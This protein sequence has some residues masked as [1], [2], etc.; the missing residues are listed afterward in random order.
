MEEPS[1]VPGR[2]VSAEIAPLYEQ[3]F[4]AIATRDRAWFER[5]FAEDLRVRNV[6]RAQERGKEAMIALE[7][8]IPPLAWRTLEVAAT[9]YA[10]V[11]LAHWSVLVRRADEDPSSAV[12]RL[13]ASAWR[14]TEGRWQVF[15]HIGAA[16]LA[17]D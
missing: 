10:E 12:Q 2:D 4:A 11:A 3:W 15:D 6:M 9:A 1:P 14:Q 17:H 13:F 5:H 16:D 7:L 8:S